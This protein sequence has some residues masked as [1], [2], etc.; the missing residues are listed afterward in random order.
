MSKPKKVPDFASEDEEREFWA[1]HDA[2]EYL[3]WRRA[4]RVRFPNLKPSSK[5]ISLRL[6]ESMLEELKVLAH[7]QTSKILGAH[8]LGPM[9]GELI[10]EIAVAM[11]AGLNARELAHVS[12]AHPTLSEAVREAAMAAVD[13]PIHS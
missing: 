11:Q 5:A 7:E 9:A 13:K 1:T 6:P 8:M 2:T 12:H 3:D 10:H 4:R